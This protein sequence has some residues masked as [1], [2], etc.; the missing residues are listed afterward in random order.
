VDGHNVSLSRKKS[1]R[2]VKKFRESR[3]F[4]HQLIR[5]TPAVG[6]RYARE[7]APVIILQLKG[8]I[9]S[10]LLFLLCWL[11]F[12][13]FRDLFYLLGL[14]A[15]LSYLTANLLALRMFKKI[16]LSMTSD[17]NRLGLKPAYPPKF[18]T[19]RKFDGWLAS[20]NLSRSS[21]RQASVMEAEKRN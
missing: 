15:W 13:H 19:I 16:G 7:I 9:L 3:Q 11:S 4:S 6:D 8:A 10:L 12:A 18:G 2:M 21:I 1:L 14:L 20:E 17:L 5:W